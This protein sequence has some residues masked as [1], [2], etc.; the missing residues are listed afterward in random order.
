MS[1]KSLQIVGSVSTYGMA[2]ACVL[3]STYLY[4]F[5]V[6]SPVIWRSLW[7]SMWIICVIFCVHSVAGT[8]GAIVT[9]PLEVVKTRLQSSSNKLL[10]ENVCVPK[11]ASTSG[12]DGRVTCK[13]IRSDQRRHISTLNP[14][15][16]T[17][18]LTFSQHYASPASRSNNSTTLIRALK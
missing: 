16:S 6:V 8:A 15:L 13:T 2:H 4:R 3:L 18:M 1:I 17:H 14:R 11:I 12:D 9:C 10:L 5:F 7:S